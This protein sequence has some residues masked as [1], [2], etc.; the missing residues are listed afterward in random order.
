M[1]Q[2]SVLLTGKEKP[3]IILANRKHIG[4]LNLDGSYYDVIIE[5]RSRAIAV[6]FDA[7]QNSVY[8]SD[9]TDNAIYKATAKKSPSGELFGWKVDIILELNYFW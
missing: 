2:V 1:I 5:N 3:W 7:R 8:W 4:R 6:D 9:V